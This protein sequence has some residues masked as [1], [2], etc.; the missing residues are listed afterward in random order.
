MFVDCEVIDFLI[1]LLRYEGDFTFD[2]ELKVMSTGG[3][4]SY[5]NHERTVLFTRTMTTHRKPRF[6]FV[7][8]LN[9]REIELLSWVMLLTTGLCF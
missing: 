2:M 6:F 8:R 5:E 4:T 3:I 1:H 7:G 9:T